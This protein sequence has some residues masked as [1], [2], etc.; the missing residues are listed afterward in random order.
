[1]HICTLPCMAMASC[2]GDSVLAL[3]PT[4]AGKTAVA[5]YAFAMAL[6]DRKKRVIYTSPLKALSSQKFRALYEEFRDVG[7][8][9]G[10]VTINSEAS[11]LFMTTEIFRSMVRRG[12]GGSG[13]ESVGGPTERSLGIKLL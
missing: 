6:R 3:V 5:E 1:M 12:E 10:D 11:C 8:M 7:L 9:T 2:A 13:L 4:S